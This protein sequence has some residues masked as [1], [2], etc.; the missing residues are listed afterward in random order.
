MAQHDIQLRTHIEIGCHTEKEVWLAYKLHLG[1]LAFI[2]VM[3]AAVVTNS[4]ELCGQIIE[5]QLVVPTVT[6]ALHEVIAAETKLHHSGKTGR[7]GHAHAAA[8]Q[9]RVI[10]VPAIHAAHSTSNTQSAGRIEERTA[11]DGTVKLFIFLLV[12]VGQITAKPHKRTLD[13]LGQR[14]PLERTIFVLC[15]FVCNRIRT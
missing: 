11:K 7:E 6:V 1:V 14:I 5:H 15:I 2:I 8:L 12:R 3:Q 4:P 10:A 9:C 13:A